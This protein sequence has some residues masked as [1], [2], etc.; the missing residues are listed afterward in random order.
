MQ[1]W[2]KLYRSIQGNEFYFSERFTKTQAWTDL[3][4]L[5]NHKPATIFL[6]GVEVHLGKGALAYSQLSLAKRWKWN[7][8]TV[9]KFLTMLE[10]R[11][12]IHSRKSNITT[13]ISIINYAL[14]QSSTE[15][16]TEQSTSRLQ[17]DKNDKN[18]EN[19]FVGQLIS[20]LKENNIDFD[21]GHLKVRITKALSTYEEKIIRYA[22]NVAV[23]S[24]KK[25]GNEGNF[26]AYLFTIL[27]RNYQEAKP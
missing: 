6:R 17:T 18:E 13:V 22:V 3:L 20:Y 8:R 19:V 14:Y 15:Q 23:E 25:N 9:N 7:E 2:I 5:A 10:K 24:W 16:S 11:Q 27:E 1:G 21:E 12:M 26:V 4:L